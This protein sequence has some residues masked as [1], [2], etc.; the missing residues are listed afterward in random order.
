MLRGH[1]RSTRPPR[2]ATSGI[3]DKLHDVAEALF[4]VQQ[5]PAAGQRLAAARGAWGNYA[6]AKGNRFQRQAPLILRPAPLIVPFLQIRLGQVPVR[7]GHLRAEPH[8]L[9]RGFDRFVEPACFTKDQP[10]IAPDIRGIRLD[11]EGGM[12]RRDRFVE[13][14]G[15]CQRV[16][17]I[18]LR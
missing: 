14:A 11:A 2:A 3:A 6:L 10:E 18:V 16:G 4:R 9:R 17:K 12:K 1:S 8:G 15:F 13:P 7:I 5:D